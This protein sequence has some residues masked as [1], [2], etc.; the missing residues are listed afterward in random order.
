[1]D[2]EDELSR[3]YEYRELA[4]GV[5]DRYVE[6]EAA[7]KAEI[8][9]LRA[10]VVHARE[11]RRLTADGPYRHAGRRLDAALAVLDDAPAGA[12]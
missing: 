2:V 3:L 5:I 7:L 1:M 12:V 6:Y 8:E 4:A 11:Y 9:R 10:V